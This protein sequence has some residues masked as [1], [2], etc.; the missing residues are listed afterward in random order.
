M[1]TSEEVHALLY[2]IQRQTGIALVIVTHNEHL[3][4][5]MA[6]TIRMV[7]GKVVESA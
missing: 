5:G 3:A 2:E 7:D 4:A 6:R 1:K